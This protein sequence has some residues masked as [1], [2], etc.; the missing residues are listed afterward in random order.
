VPANVEL[1]P[2]SI[3]L[4]RAERLER[5]RRCLELVGLS[6]F[7]NAYPGELSG[8]MRRRVALAR[9]LATEPGILLMDRPFASIDAQTRDLMQIELVRIRTRW[10]PVVL[11]VTH[12]GDEAIILADRIPVLGPRPRGGGRA[13]GGRPRTAALGV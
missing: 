7:G 2:K 11:L 6:R 1:A 10:R 3:P 13:G 9:T 8:G 4:G 12:G 5:V